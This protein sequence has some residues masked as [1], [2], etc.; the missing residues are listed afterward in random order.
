M[1]RQ[2]QLE[3]YFQVMAYEA[4]KGNYKNEENHTALLYMMGSL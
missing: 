3:K 2:T 4:D 1:W